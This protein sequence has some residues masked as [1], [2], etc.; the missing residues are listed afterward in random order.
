MGFMDEVNQ[1]KRERN[2]RVSGENRDTHALEKEIFRAKVQ[3]VIDEI[4]EVKAGIKSAASKGQ[5]SYMVMSRILEVH[6][7]VF[8]KSTEI[9]AYTSSLRSRVANKYRCVKAS[10]LTSEPDPQGFNGRWYFLDP[11]AGKSVI[12]DEKLLELWELLESLGVYPFFSG[13]MHSGDLR[14]KF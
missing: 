14:V 8:G 3:A 4:E 6:P 2:K 11:K 7:P 12:L 5:D 1:I 10:L 13:Q 9:F